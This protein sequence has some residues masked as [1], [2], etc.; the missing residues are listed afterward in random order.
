MQKEE[1]AKTLEGERLA[2]SKVTK[3]EAG[4]ARACVLSPFL[5]VTSKKNATRKKRFARSRERMCGSTNTLWSSAY[6]P[7]IHPAFAS[8]NP[9]GNTGHFGGGG[10]LAA[11]K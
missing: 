8:R 4:N 5:P 10:R 11:G 2:V 9:G 7:P 3:A 1:K 6:R